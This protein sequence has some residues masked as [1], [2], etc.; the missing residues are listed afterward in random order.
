MSYSLWTRNS[1]TFPS[2]LRDGVVDR[3][4]PLLGQQENE[5]GDEL[6]ADRPDLERRIRLDGHV[7]REFSLAIAFLEDDR[8]LSHDGDGEADEPPRSHLAGD[9]RV[10]RRHVERRGKGRRG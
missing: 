1:C 8:P 10:D 2:T 5:R 7:G 3:Q 9:V 4:L 6:L